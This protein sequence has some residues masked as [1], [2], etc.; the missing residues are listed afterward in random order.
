M[1][2]YASLVLPVEQGFGTS[3]WTTLHWHLRPHAHSRDWQRQKKYTRVK[4][5]DLVYSFRYSNKLEL[6]KKGPDGVTVEIFEEI[7]NNSI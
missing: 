3:L 5:R 6:K 2:N 4:L 1:I 7:L